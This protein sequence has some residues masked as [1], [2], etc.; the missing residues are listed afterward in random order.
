MAAICGPQ[1]QTW[2]V[3]ESLIPSVRF[4]RKILA[5]PGHYLIRY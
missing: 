2:L 1:A 3:A 5:S 4:S